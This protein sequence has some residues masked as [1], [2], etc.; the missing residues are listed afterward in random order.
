MSITIELQ[1]EIL[2]SLSKR[3]AKINLSL[4]KYIE[5]ILESSLEEPNEETVKAIQEVR[6]G[7]YAGEID[8]SSIESMIRS[9]Q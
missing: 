7:K 8:L 1:N 6:E 9:L 2:D 5:R 4:S 3:A